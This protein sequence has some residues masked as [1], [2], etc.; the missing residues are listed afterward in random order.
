MI[1]Q[2]QRDPGAA[3]EMLRR[4]AFNGVRVSQLDRDVT[5][6][7]APM[8]GAAGSSRW[9][10]SSRS[11]LGSC[12]SRRSTRTSANT[13][14]PPE[15]P[16]DAAGWTLPFQMDV[17]RRRGAVAAVGR[18][19]LGAPPGASASR[20]DWRASADAPF[21]TDS[22]ASGIVAS[23]GSITGSG[24]QL[25]LDPAQNNAFRLINRA[26]AAGGAVRAAPARPGAGRSVCR[27]GRP[28]RRR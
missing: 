14:R 28:R 4:L 17:Q 2:A 12:S 25:A 19:A 6:D 21:S 22:V 7:G 24:D 10:R 20:S 27:L 15:Q 5:I 18:L 8:P 26:F 13:P 11:L 23:A 3:A 16:Y 1:P 9:I